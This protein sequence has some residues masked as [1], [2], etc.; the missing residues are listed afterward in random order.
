MEFTY[1]KLRLFHY[2]LTRGRKYALNNNGMGYAIYVQE[3]SSA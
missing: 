2:S 1:N 3:Q